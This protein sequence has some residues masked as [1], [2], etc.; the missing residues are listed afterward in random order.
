VEA[1]RFLPG[2]ARRRAGPKIEKREPAK[3]ASPGSAELA[4]KPNA[5]LAEFASILTASIREA[6]E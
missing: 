1:L 2:E 6:S 4:A 5:S 3:Q